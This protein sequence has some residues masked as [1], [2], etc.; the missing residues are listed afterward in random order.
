MPGLA[1]MF[2]L[3][4]GQHGTAAS[5]QAQMMALTQGVLMTGMP[6][7]T[8]M[9]GLTY[10]LQ[11]IAQPTGGAK[12]A[13][14]GIGITP[15]FVQQQGVFAAVMRLLHT[16]SPVSRG[17]AKQLGAIP[18]ETLDATNTLPGIPA[19]ELT[20]LRTMIPRIHGIR[21]AIILAS[22]L[23]S[24]GDV[25][26]IAQDLTDYMKVQDV[27]SKQAKK[28]NKAAQDLRRNAN[29]E[30]AAISLHNAGLE[31]ARAFNPL[32]AHVT[33]GI[34]GA[35]SAMRHHPRLTHDIALGGAGVLAALGVARFTGIP[36]PGF[37][38]R[39]TGATGQ[40]LVRGEATKAAMSG[41]TGLGASPQNPLYVIVVGQLFGGGTPGPTNDP[42]P[43]FFKKIAA[44]RAGQ[45]LLSRAGLTA[46]GSS[47]AIAAIALAQRGDQGPVMHVTPHG[48]I[49]WSPTGRPYRRR[50]SGVPG[51]LE[52][53]NM[54]L[55]M[56][57]VHQLILSQARRVFG[58]NIQAV[59][60][61]GAGMW[62]GQA[63][64]NMTI[65]REGADGRLH[66]QR[67]HIPVDMWKHGRHP[68]H[69]GRKNIRTG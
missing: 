66:R 12:T 38:G 51:N 59:T 24:R 15:Q 1:S 45:L 61:Y 41:A 18:D 22:Q 13:L 4:P 20:A 28:V 25:Q 26:S 53:D 14:A 37:L 23:Q 40:A 36:L 56:N 34:S 50:T 19:N 49:V 33:H 32:I 64:I 9:R 52:H 10:L 2:Q 65:T 69:R 63:D 21:A 67:V 47:A 54:Q 60:G 16:I 62:H 58:G 30:Q 57:Q 11:S 55:P 48:E 42:V 7:A 17:R 5:R 6:A 68:S 8:G 3:A 29:M 43:S 46:A 35:T 39:I 27:N 31:I 44:G